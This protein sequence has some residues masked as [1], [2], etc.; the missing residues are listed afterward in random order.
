MS[1]RARALADD[2]ERANGELTQLVE[3]LSDANWTT[4][5]EAERWTVAATARHIAAAHAF[6]ALRVKAVAEQQP[7]PPMPPGGLD[8]GNAADAQ[9]YMNVPP[10]EVLDLLRT[11]GAEAATLVRGLSDE[12]LDRAFSRPTG[13]TMTLAS[14]IENGLIGHLNGHQGSIRSAVGQ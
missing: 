11:N 12:Q 10:A 2:F 13:E 8:A 5:T 1:D 7:L 9:Q 14:L 6:I 3:G 4:R